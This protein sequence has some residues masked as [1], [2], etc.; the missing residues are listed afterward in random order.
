MHLVKCCTHSQVQEYAT[1]T[2]PRIPGF[3]SNHLTKSMGRPAES[4]VLFSGNVFVIRLEKSFGLF[5]ALGR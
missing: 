1:S 5:A 2:Q 3:A 4:L